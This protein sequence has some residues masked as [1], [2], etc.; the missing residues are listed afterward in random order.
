MARFYV[1]DRLVQKCISLFLST[2]SLSYNKEMLMLIFNFVYSEIFKV[3]VPEHYTVLSE[4]FSG[5]SLFGCDIDGVEN[6]I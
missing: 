1:I 5:K 6:T 3:T 2:K 4:K